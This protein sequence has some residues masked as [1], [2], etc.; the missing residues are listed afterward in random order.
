MAIIEESGGMTPTETRQEV[1]SLLKE[2]LL[3][4]DPNLRWYEKGSGVVAFAFFAAFITSMFLVLLG[5][6]LLTWTSEAIIGIFF[7]VGFLSAMAA[8]K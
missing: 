4:P 2:V 8:S 1:Q 3:G 6:V 7:L 5:V